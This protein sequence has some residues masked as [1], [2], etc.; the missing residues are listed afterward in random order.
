MTTNGLVVEAA[1]DGRQ[2]VAWTQRPGQAIADPQEVW[3]ADLFHPELAPR[4]LATRP[5]GAV[6]SP[7]VG[8]DWVGWAEDGEHVVLTPTAGGPV[9]RLPG[10]LATGTSPAA[11]G[12]VIGY[13]AR[14]QGL[15]VLQVL[16]IGPSTAPPTAPAVLTAEVLATLPVQYGGPQRLA[17]CGR[18]LAYVE[19]Q[20]QI[21]YRSWRTDTSRT[22]FS[23]DHSFLYAVRRPYCRLDVF[24]TVN[25][26]NGED[27]SE[28]GRT[29][30]LDLHTGKLRKIQ[31]L[32]DGEVEVPSPA[33][34]SPTFLAW[35]YRGRVFARPVEGGETI[36]LP[37]RIASTGGWP[38]ADGD[39][40]TYTVRDHGWTRIRVV[41][42]TSS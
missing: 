11:A 8:K 28:P 7:V 13:V 34:T 2:T 32:P 30:S 27:P 23:T 41:R 15:S 25:G 6:Y 4:R 36:R 18:H 3:T 33:T 20:S 24:D 19:G 9:T 22:V 12:R 14:E 38:V 16:K 31:P 17:I 40:V 5:V 39:L 26:Y 42:V 10:R 21:V 1:F 37:G 35:A 29:L